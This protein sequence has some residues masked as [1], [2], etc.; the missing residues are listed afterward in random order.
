MPFGGKQRKAMASDREPVVLGVWDGHEAGVALVAGGHLVFALSEERPSRRKRHSGFPHLALVR[1]LAYADARGL[2]VTD[3][4]VAG[5]RGRAPLRLLES[6]YSASSPHRDPLSWPSR[7]VAGWENRL[8]SL[9]ALRDIETLAGLAPVAWRLKSALGRL[10]TMRTVAHHDAHAFAALL[11]PGDSESR[12]LTWDAYGEGL[13]GTLR[14]AADP[15]RILRCLGV[16]SSPAALY[17][18]VTVALGFRE[19]DEGKVMG[20]AARGDP[21]RVLGRFRALMDGADGIP[22]LRR[23]LSRGDIDALVAG[24]A[25]Q[26]VAAGLQA[27]TEE[28]VVSAVRAMI[29]TPARPVRLRLAGGLFANI[30]VNQ[31]L[32]TLPGIEGVRVF[33][34]MGDGGLAA[35][36]AA[37][38]WRRLTGTGVEPLGDVFLGTGFDREALVR[39]AEASG[40]PFKR[41]ADPGV[42]AAD[43]LARGAVVARYCG[44]DEFGPRALGNRSILF[45]PRRPELAERVNA[46]LERDD[47]M[48]FGPAVEAGASVGL[49]RPLSEG[50][51]LQTMTV[52]VDALPA[53]A[54]GCPVAV[55]RD[56]TSRPQ[57]VAS[58]VAPGFAGILRAFRER[59]GLPALINTSFNLHGEP[60]VHTPAQ[61]VQTFRQAGFEVLYLDDLEIRRPDALA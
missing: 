54:D 49:W 7:V 47:F 46:A 14:S 20:L 19:G 41:V 57:V 10:P 31:A 32:A 40:L 25:S 24:T 50:T 55:H 37:W 44:R 52:A 1:A 22:S 15:D 13:S 34:A 21:D 45:S 48:P 56:G 27:F 30:R 58:E 28:S 60:I 17:G 43:W 3:V 16:E 6:W 38:V 5:R 9:V 8:G 35:G 36:A 33:P 4:A 12:V 42:A 11:C 59:T 51:D 2:V 23:P 61:A 39:A 29:G 18:A 26:D 53:L